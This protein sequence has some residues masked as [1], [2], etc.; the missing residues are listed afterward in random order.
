MGREKRICD[1]KEKKNMR[2][3]RNKER[4]GEIDKEMEIWVMKGEWWRGREMRRRE[5]KLE[6]LE[7]K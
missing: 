2:D 5:E 6:G 4:E 3:K 7:E 1:E